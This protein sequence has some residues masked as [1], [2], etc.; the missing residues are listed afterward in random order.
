MSFESMNEPIPDFRVYV[1]NE[2]ESEEKPTIKLTLGHIAFSCTVDIINSPDEFELVTE[3]AGHDHSPDEI[4]RLKQQA[5]RQARVYIEKL[6]DE[7]S[8]HFA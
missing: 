5:E 8:E 1:S 3:A 2:S 7:Y 6:R 4:N